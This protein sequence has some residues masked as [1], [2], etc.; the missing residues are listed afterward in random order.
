MGFHSDRQEGYLL[1]L[2]G[3]N[4]YV[5]CPRL[6]HLMYVQGL[7]DESRD[8]LEGRIAHTKRVSKTKAA[9]PVEP[10]VQETT[11]PWRADL[12]RELTLSSERI[13]I[14]GKFDIVLE[15]FDEIVP[16]EIKHGP[17]PVG[18]AP[19]QVGP[20]RLEGNAWGNDQ[21]QL[22]GQIALLR[23]AGYSCQRGRLY[24]RQ[25]ASL[26]ELAFSQNLQASLDWV[27]GQTLQLIDG[28]MPPP[29][30][31]SA[32]CIRCSLNYICLPDETHHL[33]GNLE[34][35]RQ[36]YPGREDCG[37]LHI[38]TPGTR[39]GK[40][41]EALK[42]S[43]PDHKDELVPIKD[44]A[45]VCCWGNVQIT[46]QAMLELANRGIGIS[47]LSSGGWL[48]ATTQAPLTKNVYLRRSQYRICDIP[49]KCLQLARAVVVS[50]IQN[51]RVLL[52]RNA[53]RESVQNTLTVLKRCREDA[54]HATSLTELR[55]H[56]G[57][58]A[59]QYWE[60]FP[61][62]L[63]ETSTGRLQMDGRNRRPPQ[64]PVNAL[65]SFGYAML[66]RDFMTVLH[67]VGLDPLYGFYHAIVPGRPALALD[68][69]EAFRPLVVD[70]ALVRAVN[71]GSFSTDDFVTGKGFCVLKPHAKVRWIQAYERRV[72]ELIS[73]PLFGYRISYRRMFSLESR[74]LGR[75]FDGELH[76]YKPITTR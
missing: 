34:D 43:I 75:Y 39:L 36:L 64:D 52:Q 60:A 9:A 44:I 69:M 18:N 76:E 67:G 46:T 6:F 57:F 30:K 62:V 10:E 33:K 13:G 72:D 55:G 73:H 47:W 29:L 3:L 31:D 7:F 4:E 66:L 2:R 70:S 37:L 8:T 20:Y 15:T 48:K 24:Y 49:A 51:Q 71:E 22:A 56:E 63:A 74:L 61:L 68:M 19:F 50:K 53:P 40:N 41:D 65:L 14:T 42:I 25:S 12:V 54:M 23:E 45:H 28:E 11:S 59:K 26:V 32:K 58:A 38:V 35:P 21:V 27:V 16:V 17:A 1:P 5:Y